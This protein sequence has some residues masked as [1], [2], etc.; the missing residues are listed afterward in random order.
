MCFLKK[1]YLFLINL[2]NR[3]YRALGAP[4]NF[5]L[6]IL[7]ICEFVL[8]WRRHHFYSLALFTK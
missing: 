5:L 3:L 8:E 7:N 6:E 2:M 4:K 1:F